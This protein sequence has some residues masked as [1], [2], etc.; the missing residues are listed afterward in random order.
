MFF[1]HLDPRERL[2]VPA[3]LPVQVV[4]FET[5]S[6]EHIPSLLQ[7]TLQGSLN[8]IVDIVQNPGSHLD[9]QRETRLK[10]RVTDGQAGGILVDLNECY[11]L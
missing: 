4:H 10:H 8:T 1:P 11:V 5:L 9:G 7:N 2:E 6:D 3:L